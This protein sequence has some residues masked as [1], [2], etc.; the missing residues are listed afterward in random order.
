MPI[1]F[2][3]TLTSKDMYRFNM[4]QTYSGFHGW[5]SVAV[6]IFAFI[7]AGLTYGKVEF[8]Y[9]LLYIA[10]GII[11]LLYLPVTLY[12]RS[13]HS[14]AA[15]RILG[16]PLHYAVDEEGIGVSQGEENAKL[17]WE[18]IYKMVATKHNVLVYSNRINA[19]VIPREQLGNRYAELAGLAV[20]KL[21]KY[22]V[23]MQQTGTR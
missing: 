3:I 16:K 22:R 15:S 14:P 20:S 7:A 5:F 10:F 2:D 6:S 19:Y 17:P 12:I 11:F 8:T 1:E 9:T 23:K 21:E 4:Y 13:G 18:Q